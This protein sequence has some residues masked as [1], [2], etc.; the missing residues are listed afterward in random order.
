HRGCRCVMQGP[1]VVEVFRPDGQF[2][3]FEHR[4]RIGKGISFRTGVHLR[5]S[6][7]KTYYRIRSAAEQPDTHILSNL[8]IGNRMRLVVL[9]VVGRISRKGW[10]DRHDNQATRLKSRLLQL[11][12]DD[13]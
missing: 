11:R 3:L 10:S 12:S 7:A 1:D 2:G 13:R 4:V 5:V 6:G 9:D 8:E